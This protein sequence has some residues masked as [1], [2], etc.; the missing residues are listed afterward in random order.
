MQHPS[1]D[2]LERELE[3]ISEEIVQ[4]KKDF[5]NHRSAKN[6]FKEVRRYVDIWNDAVEKQIASN[7]KD[8][9]KSLK[10][11][12]PF[13][14]PKPPSYTRIADTHMTNARVFV[15]TLEDIGLLSDIKMDTVADTSSGLIIYTAKF[16]DTYNSLSHTLEVLH[17][18]SR[19]LKKKR[20]QVIEKLF[21]ERCRIFSDELQAHYRSIGEQLAN[22]GDPDGGSGSGSTDVE[23]MSIVA[24]GNGNGNMVPNYRQHVESNLMEAYSTAGSS[25][26]G[27]NSQELLLETEELPSY[28]QYE[29]T[30]VS[31]HHHHHNHDH[32]YHRRTGSLGSPARSS[33]ASS[34][35]SLSSPLPIAMTDSP[36]DYVRTELVSGQQP[37]GNISVAVAAGGGSSSS[38]GGGGGADEDDDALFRAYQQRYDS[39]RRQGSDAQSA[40]GTTRVSL[41]ALMDTPP[42]YDETR[43]HT[44]VDPV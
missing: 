5:E 2:S 7:A 41:T 23:N 24:I 12:V 11:F 19:V 38:G 6:E 22:G 39:H 17:K 34:S 25:T 31:L 28:F 27:F 44:V 3:Q 40:A 8:V 30:G 10:K 15:P 13:L 26:L 42:G 21:D 36:P 18:K 29:A 16:K 9:T 43:Y 32:Q 14:G 33:S 20:N 1:E 35:L 37:L 4:V